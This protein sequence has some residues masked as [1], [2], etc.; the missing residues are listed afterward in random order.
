MEIK[1]KGYQNNKNFIKGAS[2]PQV[3]IGEILRT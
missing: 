2:M 3:D 1:F